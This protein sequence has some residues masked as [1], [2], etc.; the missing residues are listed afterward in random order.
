MEAAGAARAE[1]FD[2]LDDLALYSLAAL[3][4]AAL[5]QHRAAG[6]L[7]RLAVLRRDQPFVEDCLDEGALLG[8]SRFDKRQ[9]PL[10]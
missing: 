1:P 8:L 7:E 10:E 6:A 9:G 3:A 2:H 5:L 4:V